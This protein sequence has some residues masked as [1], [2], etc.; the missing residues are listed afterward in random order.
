MLISVL[1]R[2][3]QRHFDNPQLVS[4][5]FTLLMSVLLL[6]ALCYTLMPLVVSMIMTYLLH[7]LVKSV[8]DKGVSRFWAVLITYA[9]FLSIILACLLIFLPIL[10]QQFIH[11]LN[12]LPRMFGRGQLFL[13]NFVKEHPDWPSL[14]LLLRNMADVQGLM[15]GLGQLL[16]SY[17]LMSLSNLMQW[18]VYL[19]LVPLLV[20]FLLKDTSSILIWL[21]PC[22]PKHRQLVDQVLMRMDRKVGCYIKGRLLEMLVVG[23]AIAIVAVFMKLP[24]AILVGTLVGVSVLIPIIGAV[25]VSLF[26][27]IITFLAWGLNTTFIHF[28][29]IYA[30]IILLDA[31]LLVPLLFAE[32]MDLHPI[33]VI[34]A[35]LF[36]G[37]LWGFWGLFFAIPLASLLK[38]ILDVWRNA[39][40]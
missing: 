35:V 7:I 37:T 20:F 36:F 21:R 5:F 34:I 17:S 27:V 12:E 26:V 39:L 4:L 23:G 8:Q 1:K 16:L 11:L 29:I 18:I 40:A 13:Q 24:Y 6:V 19:I 25:V 3:Y 28:M 2:L 15:A 38:V 30:V 31:N 14:R 33:A 22:W 32:A 9:L 10:S